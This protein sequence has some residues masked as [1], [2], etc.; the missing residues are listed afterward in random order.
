[1]AR[2]TL[3]RL[4]ATIVMLLAL[5]A[6][7]QAASGVDDALAPARPDAPLLITPWPVSDPYA[8][9]LRFYT[10]LTFKQGWAPIRSE[11]AT[12]AVPDEGGMALGFGVEGRAGPGE[13]WQ[14]LANLSPSPFA[15]VFDPR[16]SLHGYLLPRPN[17][18]LDG[19]LSSDMHGALTTEVATS[20]LCPPSSLAAPLFYE[21]RLALGRRAVNDV[22]G[23]Y[24]YGQVTFFRGD[25]LASSVTAYG[26][27]DGGWRGSWDT[28]RMADLTARLK[29]RLDASVG[30]SGGPLPPGDRLGAGLLSQDWETS[31]TRASSRVGLV[32]PLWQGLDLSLYHLITLR[33]IEGDG[34]VEGARLWGADAPYSDGF[35]AGTGTEIVLVNDTCFGFPLAL[36][37][38]YALP[39]WRQDGPCTPWPGKF[40]IGTTVATFPLVPAQPPVPVP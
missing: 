9:V 27:P 8:N 35:L 34:Y 17:F 32:A 38:G 25:P 3:W 22:G 7:A 40:Y 36:S 11:D 14:V 18:G 29:L 20:W 6:P 2:D 24:G 26:T 21:A 33:Q 10:G 39:V 28:T 13:A 19:D 23:G 12:P 31:A 1:M 16:I 4:A 15:P 30:T 37:L 5:D